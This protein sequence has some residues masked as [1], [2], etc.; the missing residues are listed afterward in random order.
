MSAKRFSNLNAKSSICFC[1]CYFYAVK[2][3]FGFQFWCFFHFCFP[4][5]CIQCVWSRKST[6]SE[7]EMTDHHVGTS[8]LQVNKLNIN[9]KGRT[10]RNQLKKIRKSQR[11]INNTTTKDDSGANKVKDTKET[12]RQRSNSVTFSTIKSSV[13]ALFG[14]SLSRRLQFHFNFNFYD[15]IGVYHSESC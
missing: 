12:T 13:S 2:L 5:I 11:H 7:F 15:A 4:D 3:H 9:I 1:F 14:S 6:S 10:R 8:F